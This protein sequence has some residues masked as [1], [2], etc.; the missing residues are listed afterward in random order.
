MWV[1]SAQA[2]GLY[3]TA[4]AFFPWK[5]ASVEIKGARLKAG[6][7]NQCVIKKI[8]HL[9]TD[10][11]FL[12][13][14][15]RFQEP[16]DWLDTDAYDDCCF[17]LGVVRRDDYMTAL[18]TARK[19]NKREISVTVTPGNGTASGGKSSRSWIGNYIHWIKSADLTA[20]WFNRVFC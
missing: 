3:D 7:I 20:S 18:K 16:D 17:W 5:K 8:R 9:G 6:T 14:V 15:C 2:G 10:W 13:F 12:V 11:N 4:D 19:E 1:D